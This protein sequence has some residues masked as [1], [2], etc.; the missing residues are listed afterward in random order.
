MGGF[1]DGAPRHQL[2][3]SLRV[4]A[5]HPVALAHFGDAFGCQ[6]L[7]LRSVWGGRHRDTQHGVLVGTCASP[8]ALCCPQSSGMGMWRW[9][10]PGGE[11]RGRR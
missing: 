11:S 6:A 1:G 10:L 8:P 7:L 3:L 2:P 4:K 5:E 9:H